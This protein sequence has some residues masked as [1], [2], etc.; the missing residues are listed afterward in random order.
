MNLTAILAAV[1]LV[2]AAIMLATWAVVAFGPVPV[3][4]ASGALRILKEV[5]Q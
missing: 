4:L 1:L 3:I 2:V 5:V